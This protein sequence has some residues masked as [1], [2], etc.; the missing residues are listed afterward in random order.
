LFGDGCLP[1]V[2]RKAFITEIYKKGDS[3]LPSDYRPISFKTCTA[4]KIME[5]IIEDQLVSYLLC[6]GLISRQQH[7]FIK[8]IQL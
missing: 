1:P 4:C 5:A 8:N 6:K 7:A 2:W 3:C